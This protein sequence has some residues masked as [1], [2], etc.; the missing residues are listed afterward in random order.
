[1]TNASTSAVQPVRQVAATVL[2]IIA[3][4]GFGTVPFFAK[5]LTKAGMS[6][7][8][9]GFYRYCVAAV[10]L[11]PFLLVAPNLRRHLAWGM[12]AGLAMGG[13]W[14][15]YVKA[16]ETAPIAT[17][18]VLYMT[19]PV[20]TLLVAW[21]WLNERPSRRALTAAFIIVAAAAISMSPK[22]VAPNQYPV[23]L[24]SLT[25]PIGFA[26]G[27]NVLMHKL[28]Y[29]NP[30]SR[31]A[32][33]SIGAVLG[34]TPLM[35]MSDAAVVLPTN[36]NHW[37]LIVGIALASALVPQLLYAVY[38]PKIGAAKTAMAG[39][40]ELPTMF[41]IGWLAFGDAVTP[42]QWIACALVLGAI[43]L[44]ET[45]VTR[46]VATNLALPNR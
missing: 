6:S 39:S 28:V 11:S 25:A 18:G 20:F 4:I 9:V 16:V 22:A 21:F 2:V 23:L 13:G 45:R 3:A 38:A 12:A 35:L 26:F 29:L 44:T 15:G 46:N 19:Y 27:I 7:F 30:L 34:L 8:A 5:E 24:L 31:I 43:F 1:M 36:T 33:V 37:V 32:S 14:I 17:V 40:V 42:S 41:V 10:V